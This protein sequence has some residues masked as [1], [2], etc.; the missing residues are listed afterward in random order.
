MFRILG[1]FFASVALLFSLSAFA[2][3]QTSTG[4]VIGNVTDPS[5]ATIPN[6]TVKLVNLATKVETQT[7]SAQ[8][9]SFIFVNVRPGSYLLK[10]EASGFKIAQVSPVIVGVSQ[11]VSQDV[12]LTVGDVSQT[13]EVSASTELVQRSTTELG[14][15][16]KERAVLDLPLNGRNFTQLLTLT[17]GVTPVSTSQNRNVGGVEGNVGI[18]NSGFSDPSFHGQQN[19]SKLY[20]FDGIIN[21]N[22]RGPTYIVIPNIDA[23]QEFKVVGHDAKAEYGGATGGVMNMVSRSGGNSFHGSAFEYVRNNAFDARNTF[24]DNTRSEPAPFHQNQFGA[25]ISGPVIK[26]RT[27]FS[28]SYDGWRYSQPGSALSYVPTA[29]EIAGDFSNTSP[30]FRRQ[31]FNPYSTRQAGTTVVRD[32]FRCDAAGNPLPVNAQ[33]VQDQSIGSVCNKIPQALIFLPMQ[34]FFKTYSAVPN[35]SVAGDVTNNF[36]QVRP[37]TNNSN[38]YQVRVDHRFRD[39]DN[40]FFRYTEHRVTVFN[41]IGQL[42]STSGSSS[43]RN[44]GG[45]WTHAFA[46]SLILDVRAGYAG[47]PGVDSGQQNQHEAGLDPL[48]QA[49]FRDVDKYGGLLVTLA[50]WTNGGNNNFGVRGPAPRQNP[51][52][53]V[54]PNLTWLKGNHNLKTGFWY[55]EAK[56]IQENTFQ[57]YVF[58]DEQTRNPAAASGTTGL[59]LASALLGFPNNFQAQLPILHGGPV[60]FKYAAWA[61]YVQDEWRLKPNFTVNLGLRY[62]Y[63][64]QP[65][66]LDGRLWNALDLPN[67]RWIIGASTMPALCSVKKEAPCIP[68]AFLADAHVNNVILAGKDFFAPPPVKDN[69]GPRAGIAWSLN[70]KT[71]LRAGYGLYWDAIPTRSQY[72]QN[73]LEMAVWPDA[74]AFAG[75]ANATANFVNGTAANIIQLQ[76]QG[77]ATPLPTTNPWTPANT[78]GDDPNYKDGYSQQW[79]VEVQRELGSSMMLSVAYV[80]SKN[81]RLAYSGF[82][83]TARQASPNGTANSVIDALRPMPWVAANINYTLSTGYSNYN[84]LQTRFERRFSG[85]LFTLLSYTWSKSIDVSSGYFNVENGPGGGSTTQNY[86]DQSTARG[87]SSYDLTHFMSWSTLYELPFGRGKNWLTS[88]P[89]SWIAGNWQTNFIMQARSGA[90]YGLQVTGDLANLRGSAP[91]APGNYLRPNLIA[92]PFVAGPVAA[93]PDPLC[94]R[95]VSQGGRAADQVRTSASWFNVCAFGIPS[96]AFGNLGRNVYRGAAVFNTDFSL[97]KSIPIKEQMGVQLRFEFFNIFN[98]QNYDA[99]STVVI[100]TNATQIA[101]N[102]GRVTAL[103]QGTTPRQLQFGIRFT[104]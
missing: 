89:A 64:T 19:R 26:N 5:G 59:T 4:E 9:G 44:Y 25:V 72:A 63:L 56:R 51:N 14:T 12:L 37:T 94:Q 92:D 6:A 82:G 77:F 16:I 20:F 17:P 69:F 58:N 34:Q 10:V 98:I 62:D 68:D 96:G 7:T 76:S 33:K 41:P 40:I 57:T 78:F 87:V 81:G 3:A 29:A 13:V 95:T 18:P 60:R 65:K 23:I 28:F 84:A 1:K 80:G 100:N 73:D 93:N 21:T 32:A 8:N 97:F 101:A 102:V 70:S 35:Y 99:P 55:I 74:T 103:A 88:G 71:V 85:G 47:R 45:G 46:P 86:Y 52:W 66:T 48:N 31:I 22:V 27:F 91:N 11:T 49:G 24:L 90:P 79:H 53:S 38:S 67:Q 39:A 61:A 15:V 104:F 54:T 2:L 43:G 75:T 30:S 36:I 50:N 83:N 42:G